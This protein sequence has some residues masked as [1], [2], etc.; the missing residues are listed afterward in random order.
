[1]EKL[2]GAL[3]AI[4]GAIIVVAIVSVLVSNKSRTPEALSAAGGFF[5][6]VIAAAV[7]PANTAETNGNPELGTF[8]LP[9]I[10]GGASLGSGLG[11]GLLSFPNVGAFA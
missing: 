1:M 2:A 7:N 10:I 5:S 9:S 8:S 11:G 4:L 6:R 3:T